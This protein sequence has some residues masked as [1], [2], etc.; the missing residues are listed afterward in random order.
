MTRPE[1]RVVWVKA[2][3]KELG[4]FPQGLPRGVDGTDAFYFITKYEVPFD[5]QRDVTYGKIVWNYREKKE[6][7]YQA[8]LVVGGDRINYPGNVGTPTADTL[9]VKLLLNSFVSTPG[10]KVFTADISNFYLMM[11]LKR[12]EYVRLKL[13]DM[14]EDV[15]EH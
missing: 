13:S 14:P 15:V 10:A 9:S 2:Y 12:K 4:R 1:Y 11:P 3:A 7:P 5:H 6:D 8:L